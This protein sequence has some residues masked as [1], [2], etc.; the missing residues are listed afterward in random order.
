MIKTTKDFR[1]YLHIPRAAAQIIKEREIIRNLICGGRRRG[2][3]TP[4]PIQFISFISLNLS[5]W[6]LGR[7]RLSSQINTIILSILKRIY[8]FRRTSANQKEINPTK[9]RSGGKSR[10]MKNLRNIGRAVQISEPNNISE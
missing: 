1:T 4:Y 8:A 3:T 5:T 6:R 9:E 10:A 7:V 2:F